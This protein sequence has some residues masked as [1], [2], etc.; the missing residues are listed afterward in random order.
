MPQ[1]L[2]LPRLIDLYDNPQERIEETSV[3]PPSKPVAGCCTRCLRSSIISSRPPAAN[4][5]GGGPNTGITLPPDYRPTPS[6][7]NANTFFPGVETLG[8]DEMRISFV[9]SSPVPPTR[10]QAGTAI[11]V[12]LGNVPDLEATAMT[13]SMIRLAKEFGPIYRLQSP[14]HRFPLPRRV[15]R[16]GTAGCCESSCSLQ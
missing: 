1:K 16:V 5:Y 6:V 7:K 8:A 11:M 9:G 15:D 10:A 13:E 2:A 4:P 14:R 12:L 3:N